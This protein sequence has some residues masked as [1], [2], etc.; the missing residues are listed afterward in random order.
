MK[1]TMSKRNVA[2]FHKLLKK[3]API[4]D[5]VKILKVTKETLKEFTPAKCE[6]FKQS[7]I[8]AA[9]LKQK[10]EA[11]KI[12]AADTLVAAAKKVAKESK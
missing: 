9:A 6:A 1:K 12:E 5:I 10:E 2:L 7:Q 4:G 8:E 11:V 3:K